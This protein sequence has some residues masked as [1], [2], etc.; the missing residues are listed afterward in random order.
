[1]EFLYPQMFLLLFIPTL[2]LFYFMVTSRSKMMRIFS[3]EVYEK[4]SLAEVSSMGRT[5][6]ITLIFVALLLMITA[7]ARPVIDKGEREI[8]AKGSEIVVGL[9]ISRSMDVKDI[10][11]SR[12]EAAIRKI[13]TLLDVMGGDKVAIV[14]F[15]KDSFI[16]APMTKDKKVAAYLL[17]TLDMGRF[18]DRSSNMEAIV[19]AAKMLTSTEE[20]TLLILSDG[21][22]G[23]LAGIKQAVRESG[24]TVYAIGMAESKGSPIDDGRGG[25]LNDDEGNIVISAL[26]PALRDLAVGSG[27]AYTDFTLSGEDIVTL[28]RQIT[29]DKAGEVYEQEKVRDLLELFYYP[30]GMAIIF[31]LIAFHSL[32]QRNATA[33]LAAIVVSAAPAY[34]A[35]F[36]FGAMEQAKAYYE[37]GEY[38]KALG[39]YGKIGG[40]DKNSEAARLHNM[41]NSYFKLG[42]YDKAAEQYEKSLKLDKNPDTKHNLEMAKKRLEEQK[43]EQQQNQNG[44]QKEQEKDK[45]DQKGKGENQQSKADQ[46]QKQGDQKEEDAGQKQQQQNEQSGEDPEKTAKT[47]D[48]MEERRWMNELDKQ[49]NPVP[50]KK[51]PVTKGEKRAKSW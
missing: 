45:Q 7:F 29:T 25:Y 33:L 2:I 6:R 32:P 39:A 31:L 44:Q 3:D 23:D 16:I 30:L 11:P 13:K 18:G 4:L 36:D 42:Q 8:M 17:D 1:M 41:G 22:E 24:I 26:N 48:S 40:L 9:D 50:L 37:S 46:Q 12:L 51:L 5:T 34:S 21:D 27:G 20:K 35:S 10:Y 28:Y 49:P 14:A 47:M 38:Q 19:E 43:K 15:A